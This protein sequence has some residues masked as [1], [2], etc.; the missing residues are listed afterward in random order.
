M[1]QFS[2]PPLLNASERLRAVAFSCLL[3][4]Q[5]GRPEL[6]SIRAQVRRA[7]EVL[8]SAPISSLATVGATLAE[9]KVRTEALQALDVKTAEDHKA[10]LAGAFKEVRIILQRLAERIRAD[11]P[12]STIEPTDNEG[13]TMISYDVRP[14]KAASPAAGNDTVVD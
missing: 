2:D 14:G 8:G 4:V 1:H 11:A 10:L 13:V 6:P 12:T 5:A 3:K 9:E 7:R